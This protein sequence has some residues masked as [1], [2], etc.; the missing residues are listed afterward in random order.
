MKGSLFITV[1]HHFSDEKGSLHS[2]FPL[3]FAQGLALTIGETRERKTAKQ[4]FRQGLAGFLP[5]QLY[6]SLSPEPQPRAGLLLNT[7]SQELKVHRFTAGQAP[8]PRELW[9][10]CI[11]PDSREVKH[12]GRNTVFPTL[13][14]PW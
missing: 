5:P 3:R 13:I 12:I 4:G 14:S 11:V 10:L 2:H 9:Q 1:N 7:N 6:H 8:A